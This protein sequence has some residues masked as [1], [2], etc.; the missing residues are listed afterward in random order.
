MEPIK[1]VLCPVCGGC[2]AVEL[3]DE[4]VTIGENKNRVKLTHAE[5]ND[6]VARIR[7][8]ELSEV[9]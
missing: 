2:P 6:L 1:V 9:N 3:T 8:G 5:W 7:H 4:G